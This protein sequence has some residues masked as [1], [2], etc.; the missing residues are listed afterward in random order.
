MTHTLLNSKK[1]F[2]LATLF[3]CWQLLAPMSAQALTYTW[4]GG[5]GA[6]TNLW[7][8]QQNWNPNGPPNADTADVIINGGAPFVNLNINA[9]VHSITLNANT[10]NILNGYTLSLRGANPTITNNG[11]FNINA[12]GTLSGYGSLGGT[13]TFTNSG[14]ITASQ[15]TLALP[16][17]L[18]ITGNIN[19]TNGIINTAGAHNTLD[20]R[21]QITGGQINPAGGAVNLNGATLNNLTLGAGGVTITGSSRLNGVTAQG[22]NIIAQSGTLRLSG[23]TTGLGNVTLGLNSSLAVDAGG[24]LGLT[25]S[26]SFSQTLPSSWVWGGG[27]ALQ[28]GGVGTLEVGG[29]DFGATNTNFDNSNFDLVNFTLQSGATVQ[30]VNNVTNA[31]GG[32]EVLYVDSLYVP[33][34]ATLDLN[35]QILYVW[36]GNS[37]ARVYGGQGYMFGGGT[38]EGAPVPLPGSL[39]LLGTGLVGLV[40]V[41]WRRKGGD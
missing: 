30:L 16:R 14:A 2:W 23:A 7:S 25:G 22:T 41:R 4:L 38:I 11:T 27:S 15:G 6:N 1:F 36:N 19:N 33:A 31:G 17:T 28:M 39:F 9:T 18:L 21:S 13:G 40:L 12:G 10:L 32:V 35:G 29:A 20:I 8:R 34:G 37:Y 3:L 24:S 5:H 26:Y